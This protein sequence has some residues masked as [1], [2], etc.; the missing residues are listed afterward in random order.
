MA[1][2]PLA[3]VPEHWIRA[4]Q[5][6]LG[7]MLFQADPEARGVDAENAALKDKVWRHAILPSDEVVAYGKW[8]RAMPTATLRALNLLPTHL[9]TES[10]WREHIPHWRDALNYHLSAPDE[11]KKHTLLRIAAAKLLAD[12]ILAGA[13]TSQ[14]LLRMVRN[15]L[16]VFWSKAYLDGPLRRLLDALRDSGLLQHGRLAA[17]A[18]F[19][20]EV[21]EDILT[22]WTLVENVILEQ[23]FA[24][25][26]LIL[27]SREDGHDRREWTMPIEVRITLGKSGKTILANVDRNVLDAHD[28]KTSIDNARKAFIDL[29]L[30]KHGAWDEEF[31]ESIKKVNV[32]VD[33]RIANEILAGF[34]GLSIELS[35]GSLE[36]YFALLFLGIVLDPRAMETVRSTGLLWKRVKDKDQPGGDHRIR[37]PKGIRKKLDLA[38]Y[39]TVVEHFIV[40]HW[41]RSRFYNRGHLRVSDTPQSLSD[42]ADLVFGQKWRKHRYVRCPDLA[43]AFKQRLV[44]DP[45]K[46]QREALV[47]LLANNSD[48][49]LELDET[50]PAVA[51]AWALKLAADAAKAD[52]PTEGHSK[53]ASFAFVRAIE[54]ESPESFWRVVW[55]ILE[56][57]REGFA[58]F[59]REATFETPAKLLAEQL[60][61]HKATLEKPRRPPDV[62][63]ILGDRHLSPPELPPNSGPFGRFQL[64]SLIPEL[65]KYLHTD[66]APGLA[67]ALGLTRIIVVPDEGLPPRSADP[68]RG[69]PSY[70]QDALRKLSVFRFGF[71]REMAGVL[72]RYPHG[73]H[74]WLADREFNTL[75]EEL[76]CCRVDEEPVIGQPQPESDQRNG[77]RKDHRSTPPNDYFLRTPY[78]LNVDRTALADLHAAAAHALTCLTLPTA[79]TGFHF[80]EGLKPASLHEAQWHLEQAGRARPDKHFHQARE[81]LVRRG[82]EIGWWRLQQAVQASNED[83]PEVLD[84]ILEQIETA[85][86]THPLEF[87]WVVELAGRLASRSQIPLVRA[88]ALAQNLFARALHACEE[89]FDAIGEGETARFCIHSSRACL[90][91]ADSP[92]DLAPAM[93]DIKLALHFEPRATEIVT[94]DW[95]ECAGDAVISPAE[96]VSNYLVPPVIESAANL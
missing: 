83:G 64:R 17:L 26:L 19:R 34:P 33:F 80:R 96:A 66:H 10:T 87:V 68:W 1:N 79:P 67:R 61:P 62:L 92:Y 15:E 78:L 40:A 16:R 8:L 77:K 3:S 86:V 85:R 38:F 76:L 36:T 90:A 24:W 37:Q 73:H 9:S 89:Y 29:W 93:P 59:L 18:N 39:S 25:P 56:A 50:T 27:S 65:R 51:V 6:F 35:G 43:Y 41:E 58:D 23:S 95:F 57:P 49:V 47:R 70:L 7:A 71:T 72:L 55:D 88:R 45:E 22:D 60:N 53:A 81:R 31:I 94:R 2:P 5:A 28:W 4:Q 46:R 82:G 84:A 44:T 74:E 54:G 91:V 20:D 69:L 12:R 52:D 11:T 13:V 75:F 30:Y 42:M 63:V 21:S 32:E 14:Q 48:P